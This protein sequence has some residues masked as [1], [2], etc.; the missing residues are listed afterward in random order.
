MIHTTR[1]QIRPFQAADFTDLYAYLSRPEI[2]RFEPGAPITLPEARALAEA[3]AQSTDFWAVVLQANTTMIGHLYFKQIEPPE[4]LTWELGYIFHPGYHHHGYA[5]E[6]ARGLLTYALDAY[7]I[8]RVMAHCNPENHASWHLLERLGM[9]REAHL[10]QNIFFRRDEAGLP[11]WQDTY[12]YA[13][14]RADEFAPT[15]VTNR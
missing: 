8:H 4:L 5:T 12:E 6:A 7:P 14:L 15:P 13:L 10:R 11:L 1:L 9:R 3:R 2:Y